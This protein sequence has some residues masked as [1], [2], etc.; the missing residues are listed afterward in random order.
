MNQVTVTPQPPTIPTAG[1]PVVFKE[2]QIIV[3]M[4]E[5]KWDNV[6]FIN[7]D[8]EI[9]LT[10]RELNMALRTIE[11]HFRDNKRVQYRKRIVAN[12]KQRAKQDKIDLANAKKLKGTK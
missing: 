1:P 4:K 5:G 7:G 8:Y 2:K 12:E 9:P 3:T 10:P 11:L 6:D